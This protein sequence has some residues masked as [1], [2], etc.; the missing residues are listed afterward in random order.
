MLDRPIR[1]LRLSGLAQAEPLKIVLELR[2]QAKWDR[3][4]CFARLAW[5]FAGQNGA[6]Q[7]SRPNRGVAALDEHGFGLSQTER[8]EGAAQRHAGILRPAKIQKI[9]GIRSSSS[10]GPAEVGIPRRAPPA[11]G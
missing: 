5:E 6:P 2:D 10:A 11:L 1:G 7:S 9:S 8:Q 4:A 3:H